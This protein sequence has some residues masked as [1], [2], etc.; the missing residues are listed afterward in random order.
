[1]RINGSKLSRK[2][3]CH[4]GI[5][6]ADDTQWSKF[7]ILYVLFVSSAGLALFLFSYLRA[8]TSIISV[9]LVFI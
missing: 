5:E 3:N 9:N 7:L 2:S 1:M 6:K 4:F 8:I